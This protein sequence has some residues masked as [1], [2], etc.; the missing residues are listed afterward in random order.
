MFQPRQHDLLTRLFDLACQKDLIE[1][2]VDLVEVE[3]EV[4]L[5]HVPEELVQHFD[6]EM[7]RLEIRQ[8]VVVGVD[9]HA[10]E[11]ARVSSVH[12][13]GGR[14]V[15]SDEGLA[16]VRRRRGAGGAAEFDKVGL[17]L[18]IARGNESMD[19]WIFKTPRGLFISLVV[20]CHKKKIE[21][22]YEDG[23]KGSNCCIP[24]LS[25]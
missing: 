10:E 25:T 6:E 21:Q 16:V 20:L 3:H 12:D 9:A 8:L 24:R 11:Q 18:L 2:S 5:A 17:V 22:P 23:G 15:L 4:Q 7:D 19:L 13:L 1:D 14:Q